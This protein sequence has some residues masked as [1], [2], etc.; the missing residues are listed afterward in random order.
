MDWLL[1]IV[2]LSAPGQPAHPVGLMSDQRACAVAGA[3]M[4]HILAQA[5]PGL[6]F[7]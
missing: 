4:T 1:I 7:G 3:G 6:A 2:I 5:N